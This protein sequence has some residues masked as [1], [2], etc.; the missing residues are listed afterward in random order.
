MSYI[1]TEDDGW[2]IRAFAPVD[3]TRLM[4]GDWGGNA[5][6]EMCLEEK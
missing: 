5:I 4:S 6:L 2:K 3:K 1:V